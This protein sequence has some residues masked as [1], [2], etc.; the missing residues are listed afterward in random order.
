M[1]RK[2]APRWPKVPAS[3]VRAMLAGHSE[4][5]LALGAVIYLVC[6]SGTLAVFVNEF[7]LWEQPDSPIVTTVQP[8]AVGRAMQ[9]VH[10][11][12][13]PGIGD[14]Y[15]TMPADGAPRL[16]V[17]VFGPDVD[18]GWVADATGALADED[19]TPWTEFVAELH[20]RLMLPRPVGEVLVGV[21]GVALM[22]LLI[23]GL[24]AHPRIFRDAFD[25]R[26][27]GSRRLREADIHNRL[28]VWALPFHVAVT[29]TGAFFGLATVLV[30]ALTTLSH[31]NPMRLLDGPAMAADAAPAPF[32]D[33]AAILIDAEA[34]QP[35]GQTTFVGVE[36][37]GTA[38]QRVMVGIDMPSRL[39]RGERL[40]FDGSGRQI[41]AGGYVSGPL[42]LQAYAAAASLHFG[43]FGGEPV[44]LVYGV[45]GLALSVVSAGG[46]SIW[47]VRRRDQGRPLPVLEKIWPAC[48]WGT[49]L[50]LG[51]AFLGSRLL[52][53]SPVFWVTLTGLAGLSVLF[54]DGIAASRWLRAALVGVLAWLVI[55]EL[56]LSKGAGLT[57][58][59]GRI[60][61]ALALAAITIAIPLAIARRRAG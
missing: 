18:R 39:A 56:A 8:A 3:F 26:L 13:G 44:K 33:V 11:Q 46:I 17:S 38:G 42:G 54:R 25:F 36:R 55:L 22:A 31:E 35:G 7:Q 53:P 57:G 9:A 5:G 60:N 59:A 58:Y 14:L 1:S 4:L 21:V 2:A 32:P 49:P 15:A 30:A 34:A 6:L 40:Y 61:A 45:L 50:A 37:P 28:S 47:L 52:P 43:T 10:A 16:I 41:G 12:V 27:A 48:V 19:R 51:V 20:M 23:S 29:L 24:L